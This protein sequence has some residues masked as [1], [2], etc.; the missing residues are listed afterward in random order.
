MLGLR[1]DILTVPNALSFYRLAMAPVLIVLALT[2]E[3]TLFI[4]LLCVSFATDVLD[5]FIARTWNLCTPLGAR[6]DSIADELTY[7]AALVGVFQFEYEAV[8]PHLVILYIFIGFLAL[9]AL[10]PMV[11]FR[12][13]P[14]FHLYSFKA[15][16][17][18]QGIFIVTLFVFGFNAHLYYFVMGFGILACLEAIIVSLVIDQPI[19]NARSLFWVL[20][21]RNRAP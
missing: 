19:S 12:K 11:K 1:S 10:I 7:L 6:L 16:A 18:F 4:V 13:M 5:G 14:S 15:N 9:A 2:E 21:K 20:G 8:K 17:L 3:R